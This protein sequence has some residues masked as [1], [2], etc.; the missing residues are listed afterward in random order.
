[1]RNRKSRYSFPANNWASP[2]TANSTSGW[3]SKTQ[4]VVTGAE[5]Q[6][7]RVSGVFRVGDVETESLALQ[8][9]FGLRQTVSADGTIVLERH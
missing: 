3:Y 5:L 2:V 6:T 8:R 4:I 7:R 9:Y 1:M